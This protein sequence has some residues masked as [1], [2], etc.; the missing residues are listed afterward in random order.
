MDCNNFHN[1]R[2][3]IREEKK[4]IKFKGHRFTGYDG[5]TVQKIGPRFKLPTLQSVL[6][7]NVLCVGYV[8]QPLNGWR[9]ISLLRLVVTI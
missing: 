8:Q 5:I 7:V 3:G 9:G 2:Q 1:S 4:S 6:D